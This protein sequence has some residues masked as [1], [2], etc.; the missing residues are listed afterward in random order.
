MSIPPEMKE[1]AEKALVE[2]YIMPLR[3]HLDTK[4]KEEMRKRAITFYEQI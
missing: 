2:E 4:R 1:D 3:I